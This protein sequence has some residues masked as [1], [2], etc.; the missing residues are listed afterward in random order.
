MAGRRRPAAR[1]AAATVAVATL[2]WAAGCGEGTSSDPLQVADVLQA[3][4][5]AVSPQVRAAP[6]GAVLPLDGPSGAIA[7]DPVN[8]VAAVAVGNP[9]R[10]LLYRLDDLA[11]GAATPSQTV[12]LPGPAAQ[13]ELGSA[14]ELLVPVQAAAA[15]VRI[16]LRAGDG[17]AD[18]RTVTVPGGPVSAAV[19]DGRLVVGL[20]DEPAVAVLDGDRVVRTVR[21]FADTAE[22]VAVDGRV[23]VVDRLR[24]AIATIDPATGRVG[25]AL[26]AG[27]GATQAAADRF[28]RV[29]VTDTRGGELLA[30]S[31][32]PMIMRQRYPV[33]G[34]PYAIAYDSARDLVWVTLTERNEVV[35]FDVAGGEPVERYRLATVR[36]PDAVAVDSGSGTVVVVSGTGEGMQ[37]VRP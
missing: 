17:A 14:G 13:L 18:V 3:A 27:D 1:L 37:V 11:S 7:V 19:V 5:P 29:L 15:V 20:G 8:G 26:R 24:T 25:P 16:R 9:D 4:Q 30:F 34:V 21:G 32:D 35:G 23:A 36:Q 12:P 33:P 28:G 10:V 22:V 6:A 2:T 31:A